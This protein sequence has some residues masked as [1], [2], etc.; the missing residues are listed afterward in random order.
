MRLSFAL[1]PEE[2][3]SVRQERLSHDLEWFGLFLHDAFPGLLVENAS[4]VSLGKVAELSVCSSPAATADVSVFADSAVSF[5]VLAFSDYVEDLVSVPDVKEVIAQ[6]IARGCS[7]DIRRRVSWCAD[8]SQR[9]DDGSNLS[10]KSSGC[11]Q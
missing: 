7:R 5:E 4:E 1:L 3:A 8:R 11:D 6:H 10:L 9:N 2:L